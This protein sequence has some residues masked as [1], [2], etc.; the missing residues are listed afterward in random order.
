DYI[1]AHTLG[2][3]ALKA[4]AAEWPP[5]RA[6]QVCG[7]DVVQIRQL[8]EAYG[9]RARTGAAVA[10]RLNYGMQR[11]R[12]GGNAARAIACLPA[13]VGAWRRPAG[14]LL[15]SSSGMFAVQK[16]ALQRPDLLAGRTPRTINMST[17]G[18]ALNHAGNC[19][20]FVNDGSHSKAA[21]AV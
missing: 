3:D 7:V 10:I 8:A 1:A 19:H 16:D 6:A 14:G 15:L 9:Q 13:L 20:S 21:E 18:Q 5:E 11:V 17:V 4:R 2:F 12:G